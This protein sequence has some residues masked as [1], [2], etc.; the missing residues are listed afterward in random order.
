MA[1]KELKKNSLK[2]QEALLVKKEFEEFNQYYKFGNQVGG[3]A[4]IR[5]KSGQ[6][7]SQFGKFTNPSSHQYGSLDYPRDSRQSRQGSNSPTRKELSYMRPSNLFE[8]VTEDQF[9][10]RETEKHRYRIELESQ[11]ENV[12]QKRLDAKRQKELDNIEEERRILGELGLDSSQL[13]NKI[14]NGG[15]KRLNDEK[16][17]QKNSLENSQGRNK[18]PEIKAGSYPWQHAAYN[19]RVQLDAN[20]P[21]SST[22]GRLQYI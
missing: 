15:R 18:M 8:D 17:N 3:G 16:S 22:L 13:N 6:V 4:P 10:L 11:I 5:D 2:Q 21:A 9:N 7:I 1:E 19:M 20:G 12:N 14:T